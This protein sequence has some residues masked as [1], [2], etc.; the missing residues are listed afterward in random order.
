MDSNV[1][2]LGV[3][4]GLVVWPR[5]RHAA[6]ELQG[7]RRD[8]VL[9]GVQGC[10]DR[11]EALSARLRRK[12]MPRIAARP[13]PRLVLMPFAPT[14]TPLSSATVLSLV[15]YRDSFLWLSR[16]EDH[17]T[18]L[19]SS[20][21]VICKFMATLAPRSWAPRLLSSYFRALN[22]QTSDPRLLLLD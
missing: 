7:G 2:G 21:A 14:L 6:A 15:S 8:S 20:L 3:L 13:G 18:T 16:R 10:P 22:T 4:H 1:V 17:S 11:G 12:L 19:S 9:R 5:S